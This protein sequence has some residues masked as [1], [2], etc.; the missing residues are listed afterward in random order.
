M[1]P[2]ESPASAET[3]APP[4]AEPQVATRTVASGKPSSASFDTTMAFMF[5]SVPKTGAGTYP[6]SR[7]AATAAFAESAAMTGPADAD[8]SL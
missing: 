4:L 5:A 1:A 7:S 6:A 8:F 2:F 3:D